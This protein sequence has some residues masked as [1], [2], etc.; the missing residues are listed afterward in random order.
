MRAHVGRVIDGIL[1]IEVTDI[2]KSDIEK[3]DIVIE[4][5]TGN[6]S[7]N[8]AMTLNQ[9]NRVDDPHRLMMTIIGQPGMRHHIL[10][11]EAAGDVVG[12]VGVVCM[13]VCMYGCM[14][15]CMYVC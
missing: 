15:V 11:G 14:Y 7:E 12:V 5:A 6:R 8:D 13:Y 1:L 4:S 2:E 3:R 9:E 10:C